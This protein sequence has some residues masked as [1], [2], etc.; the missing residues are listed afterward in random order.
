[1]YF[2]KLYVYTKMLWSRLKERF[3]R[4]EKNKVKL[5]FVEKFEPSYSSSYTSRSGRYYYNK[6]T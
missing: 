3:I 2:T 4:D 6:Y 5:T 1:M